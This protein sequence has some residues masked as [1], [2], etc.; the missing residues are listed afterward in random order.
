MNELLISIINKIDKSLK[1]NNY[2]DNVSISFSK[3]LSFGQFQY[4]GIMKIAKKYNEN[5]KDMAIKVMNS[6]SKDKFFESVSVAGVGFINMIVNKDEI[7]KFINKVIDDNNILVP[8]NDKKK[9]IIDYGGANAAKALHVGHMRSANIGEALKRLARKMG[10]E[11]ISDVHLGDLG[12]QSGM[13]IYEIKKRNPK[14]C[15]FDKEYKGEYPKI[16][17]TSEMLKEYY[18]IA[19]KEAKENEEV[20]EEVREITS[21]V[22]SGY[23][24]YLNLW[25]Q[26]VE[27]SSKDIKDIYSKLNCSFDLWEGEMDS[28]KYTDKVLEKLQGYMYLDDGAYIVDVKEQDDRLDIPPMIVINRNGATNYETRELGTLYSRI[29]RF[30]PTEVWYVVDNRQALHF[31][32]TFRVSYKA[33]LVDKNTKLYHFGFGTINGKDGKPFKTRDG[34]VME[35]SMLTD[36]IREEITKKVSDRVEDNIKD[37]VI[38]KLTIATLKYADLSTLRSTDYIFDIDKFSSFEG[39]T[40]PYILYTEVRIKSILDKNTITDNHI[41]IINDKQLDIYLKIIELS[42]VLNKAYEEKSLNCICDYLYELCSLYN[43][44]Y[45]SVNITNEQDNNLKNS[46]LVLSKLVYDINKILLDI[47]AIDI[48]EKM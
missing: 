48:P 13:L 19:S 10:D 1:E 28:I 46:Y 18:P 32:Q 24:P 42:N 45:A 21:L 23:E 6:L 20:M 11:V 25:K 43:K 37:D 26:I 15:F 8:Q 36:M 39:K 14:L 22:E 31:I 5:S 12:R 7:L 4:N 35:L 40:G 3:N 41:K 38:D 44:F 9:V 2:E 34:G 27:V 16:E 30:N 29:E 17:I 47:L 33:S